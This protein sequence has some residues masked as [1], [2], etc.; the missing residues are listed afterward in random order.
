[1]AAEYPSHDIT[2]SFDLE[3]HLLQ[4]VSQIRLPAGQG[5]TISLGDLSVFAAK[6]NGAALD[7]GS[8]GKF[9]VDPAAF[10]QEIQLTYKK[11][12]FPAT[13]PG[14]AMISKAGISLAGPWHPLLDGPAVHRLS[15]A[16]PSRFQA[17]AE[18]EEVVEE[19]TAAGKKVSFRF[20][21]PLSGLTFV[22]APYEVQKASFGSGRE[23]LLYATS[24]HKNAMAAYREKILAYL[25]G[26]EELLGPYPFRRLVVAEN[27]RPADL[28]SPGLILVGQENGKLPTA[29]ETSLRRGLLLNWL[30][31]AISEEHTGSWRDGLI[32]Y[33]ADHEE[34]AS[35]GIDASFRKD[36]LLDYH[37]AIP[38]D[39][40]TAPQDSPA[41]EATATVKLPGAAERARAVIFLHMLRN[42]LGSEVFAAGLKNFVTHGTTAGWEG[43]RTAMNETSGQ[44][45]APFFRQ[46]LEKA[47]L[48]V[49]SISKAKLEEKGGMSLLTLQ[50]MQNQKEAFQIRIPLAMTTVSGISTRTFLIKDKETTLEIALDNSPS[51]VT[52]DP[53]YTI[54]RDLG[55][56]EVP[57]T[58]AWFVSDAGK[59]AVLPPEDQS[60]IFQPLIELLNSMGCQ[61]I[62]TDAATDA[63]VANRAVI[64]LGTASAVSRAVFADPVH[65]ELGVTVDVRKNPLG[66]GHAAV[67]VSAS[68]AGEMSRALQQLAVHEKFTYLHFKN[69]QAEWKSRAETEHGQ[70]YTLDTPPQGVALTNALDFT[71]ITGMLADKKVVYVG[72]THN[73]NEDHILQ[74]RVIR[75]LHA[76]NPEL[77]IGMEMFNHANQQALDDYINGAIDEKQFLKQSHYFETWRFDYR[78]YR[79]ILN[80]ARK[81]QIPLVALNLEKDIVSRVSKE[82]GMKALA[83]EEKEGIPGDRDLS[84]PGYRDRISQ[85]FSMHGAHG[86]GEQKSDINNFL[87]AQALWDETM[88]ESVVRYLAKNPQKRLVV[89]AGM[90][91]TD[92]E[93]AIPPRVARR[94]PNVKQA[95]VL[96]SQGSPV[97]PE[98]ADF[99]LFSLPA[100]LEPQPMLGVMLDDSETGL[101]VTGLAEQGKAK[102]AGILKDDIILSINSDPVKKMED[103]KII[104]FFKKKGDR[105]EISIQRKGFFGDKVLTVPLT[106]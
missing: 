73:R 23:L 39:S 29:K 17:V 59:L 83:G 78:F 61:T 11:V 53:D 88:A 85:A 63:D 66:P 50:L 104:M 102:E 67:L 33:L 89:V 44:D 25:R 42:E 105:L 24:G 60:G 100:P 72:E 86:G 98:A 32:T 97:P 79:D 68:D 106:L 16:I 18:A 36:L 57:P 71:T 80:F 20:P 19:K 31:A 48:P 41:A 28:A 47:P 8:A 92:K 103:L 1:M 51:L 7:T 77:A 37:I 99:V 12:F 40:G 93:N 22:A 49:L 76:Q 46:W 74:L 65:A 34:A 9:T 3:S 30:G 75:A 58:W 2:V 94:L 87:Q 90:G 91:H 69:G 54:L 5:A 55:P 64:F 13:G 56:D 81:H 35:R 4:G 15:A 43:I 27:L 70:I 96:N 6:K 10:P 82:G 45:L 21:Q 26:Y 95:V 14:T 52:I 62:A 101:L 38:T 84:L